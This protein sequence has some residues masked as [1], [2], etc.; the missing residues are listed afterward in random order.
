MKSFPA[1]V[2]E[3][4]AGEVVNHRVQHAVE[5]GQA[6]GDVK[7]GG[8]VFQSKADFRIRE[9]AAGY[10]L[11]LDPNQQ[12]C[13]VAREEANDEE[14]RHYCDEA[15]SLLNLC[16][17]GQLSPSQVANNLECAVEN[18]KQRHIEGKEECKFMPAQIT[19][20]FS[21]NHEALT[22]GCVV[23]LQSEDMS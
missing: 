8:Q 23:V 16:M 2:L 7:H 10:L 20:G 1:D 14:H 12:L 19:V 15:Q 17:L 9:G 4:R 3:D 21:L 13:D 11:E 22:V 5:I 6:N 18:H